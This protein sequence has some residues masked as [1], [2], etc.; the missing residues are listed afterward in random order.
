MIPFPIG[1][2]AGGLLSKPL[3]NQLSAGTTVIGA[4]SSA[5]QLKTSATVAM[6]AS[7]PGVAFQDIGFNGGLLD[8]AGL[9]SFGGGSDVG[10]F[11]LF[12]QTGNSNFLVQ[13][14]ISSC[15]RVTTGGSLNAAITVAGG[16]SMPGVSLGYNGV[17]SGIRN[18]EY[19]V[20]PNNITPGSMSTPFGAVA[21]WWSFSVLRIVSGGASVA[22][23][24]SS[25]TPTGQTT[26][27]IAGAMLL[28]TNGASTSSPMPLQT[29]VGA[30][31]PIA[32]GTA[33]LGALALVGHVDDGVH[34]Q[35]YVNRS[36]QTQGSA[37]ASLGA[38]GTYCLGNFDGNTGENNGFLKADVYEHIIGTTLAAAD[39]TLIQANMKAFYGTP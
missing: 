21:T 14:T 4:W 36:A 31:G 26:D 32:T 25:F 7:K 17:G 19:Q 20:G 9:I 27:V 37:S 34:S 10:A 35:I 33:P 24:I 12:D 2:F 38:T 30:S 39:L 23:R 3:L 5:R 22:G 18:P 16:K 8:T 1:L 13:I 6:H 11:S 15:P 28:A 29:F